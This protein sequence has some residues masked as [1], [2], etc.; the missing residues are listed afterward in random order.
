MFKE[1]ELE[2]T[3]WKLLDSTCRAS[4]L[5]QKEAKQNRAAINGFISGI[6]PTTRVTRHPSMSSTTDRSPHDDG[7]ALENQQEKCDLVYLQSSKYII[8][9]QSARHVVTPHQGAKRK[10]VEK[11][12]MR[13]KVVKENAI[14]FFLWKIRHL[15]ISGFARWELCIDFPLV[16][17]AKI[18]GVNKC[19]ATQ[20]AAETIQFQFQK[21]FIDSW[22]V[23]QDLY[24]WLVCVN[25]SKDNKTD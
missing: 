13:A 19:S 8:H 22:V 14:F 10:L 20:M 5:I 17:G 7:K 9:V 23:T 1:C 25:T 18:W 24:R 4:T 6:L 3:S 21:G 2:A 15:A 16:V 12:K 11:G